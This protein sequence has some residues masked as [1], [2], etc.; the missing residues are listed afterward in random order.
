M[1][2]ETVVLFETAVMLC[3][4]AVTVLLTVLCDERTAVSFIY[5]TAEMCPVSSYWFGNAVT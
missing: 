2:Y 4:T 1:L 5:E 3:E